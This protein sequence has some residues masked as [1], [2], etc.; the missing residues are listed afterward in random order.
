MNAP[1][2]PSS[3]PNI[4]VRVLPKIPATMVGAGGIG[5][6][7]V[8]GVW[9]IMPKWGDLQLI[10]PGVL[11]DPGSKEIWVHDPVS[12]VYNRMTLAG[13]GQALFW[14][15]STSANNI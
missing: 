9:T 14:G 2:F 1:L 11:L 7:K 8:S 3:R 5:I 15:S 10:A 4:S 13:L 6:S 12:D